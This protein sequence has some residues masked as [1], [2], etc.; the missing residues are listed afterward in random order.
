MFK[1]HLKIAIRQLS[2]NKFFSSL[3]ILGLSLGMALAIL[4]GL[5]V[6]NELSYDN[7]MNDS[8]ETYRVYRNRGNNTAWTPS[9][10]AAKLN[11]DY[12]EVEVAGAWAPRGEQLVAYAGNDI[13]VEHTA[14][15]DSTFFSV[16]EMTFKMGNPATAMNQPNS[17]V[18]TDQLAERIFG[19]ANPMGQVLNLDA[20]NDFTITGIIDTKGKKSHVNSEIFTR[21]TQYGTYWAGNNRTTYVQLKPKANPQQLAEKLDTD[22]TT[23]IEEQAAANNERLNKGDLFTWALQPLG[24]IYLKSEGWTSQ[25]ERVGSMRNVYIFGLIAFLI[26]F[27]AVINYV[28]LTTA[29][30]SQRS[31]EIGVKK[32]TGAGRGMLTRQ[33]LTESTL[34]TVVASVFAVLLAVAF[35]PIFN[36]VTNRELAIMQNLFWIVPTIFVLAIVIGIIAGSYPAFVMSG[37]Q[38]VTALKSNF[39]NT[40]QNGTFRKVLVTSQFTVSITL[41]IVMAFIYRQVNFMTSQDLGFKPEQVLV[42]PMTYDNAQYRVAQLKN[43]FEQIPGVEALTTASSFPGDFLP[44]WAMELEG[45]DERIVTWL[46][47]ADENFKEVLDIEMVAGRF[48]KDEIASDSVDNFIVNEEF[49]QQNNIENPIGRRIKWN[50][51]E[52]YG[53]IVGVMKNFHYR[54]LTDEIMPLVMNTTHW[55]N[56]VGFKLSTT[57]LPTTIAAIKEVWAEIEPT[58]PMRY[59]FLDENFNALYA[60]QERFGQSILYATFLTLFI[61]LLGLFGLT[62]YT[63]ERRNKEISIRKVLGASV[64]GLVGLLSKDFMKL[65]AIASV[66]AVPVGYLLADSWLTQFAY[67]TDLSWWVFAA[68]SSVILLIGFLT[69]SM[70]SMKAALTNPVEWLRGD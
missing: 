57:N 34:Q 17:M 26:L 58:H 7:W 48:M 62:A 35:L 47:Y 5:F 70:Q 18:I 54:G 68:A 53:R 32:V 63:V 12:P 45:R 56:K 41:L 23:L 15:V 38:P 42:V 49:V 50:G 22:I 19:D 27:V 2:R 3:N 39:F 14:Q 37:F 65:I 11:S 66:V 4:I 55:R 20:T 24:D 13:Y 64:T 36:T 10:L 29:R 40:G 52:E 1:N 59:S 16:L 67:R 9:P 46:M 43:R 21:F 44:D 28:N 60:E 51:S 25:V 31:K 33:F 30:A 8:E 6:Q 69:V 61:A